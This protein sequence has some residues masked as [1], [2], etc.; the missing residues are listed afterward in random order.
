MLQS[1]NILSYKVSVSWAQIPERVI[2]KI[3]M[4]IIEGECVC[5][6]QAVERNSAKER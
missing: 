1:E 3:V 2:K 4:K 6:E 5:P